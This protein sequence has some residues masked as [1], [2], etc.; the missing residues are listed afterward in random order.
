VTSAEYDT[1]GNMTS[2]T[3]PRHNKTVNKYDS[4]DRPESITDPL[5]HAETVVH[6]KNGNVTQYTD[7]NGKVNK[8]VYDALNRMTEAKIGVTGETAERTFTYTYDKATAS[9][10]SWTPRPEHTLPN[11][12]N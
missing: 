10:R 1:D 12:T 5:E 11:T 7:R 2:I 4:M 8:Y 9:Q 6:D 3:D